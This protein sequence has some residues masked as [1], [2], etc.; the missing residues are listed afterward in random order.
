MGYVCVLYLCIYFTDM[1]FFHPK[2]LVKLIIENEDDEI[3]I[4]GVPAANQNF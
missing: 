1:Y 4:I 2:L 3:F